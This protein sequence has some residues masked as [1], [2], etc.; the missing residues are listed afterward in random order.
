MEKKKRE[1]KIEQQH[2]KKKNKREK[3]GEICT[4]V[5][6]EGEIGDKEEG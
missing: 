4:E 5:E 3:E 6:A 2:Q 1:G